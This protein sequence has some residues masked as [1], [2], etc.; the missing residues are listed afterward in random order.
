MNVENVRPLDLV[1]WGATGYT[2]A[3]VAEYLTKVVGN[4]GRLRWAVGGRSDEK[5]EAL[6]HRLSRIDPA[7][8]SLERIVAG[9]DDEATLRPMVERTR[10]VCSTVGPYLLYGDL[11]VDLC[12]EAGT[13]YCDL[14][15]EVPWI[16][17]M[18]D[19]NHATAKA[20]GA[21]LVH[22]CG[23][24]SV[25]SDLG[26]FMVQQAARALHGRP[27]HE[28]KL[29]VTRSAGSLSG[30]TMAS[31]LTMIER[32]DDP[33]IPQ[34]FTD[35]YALNPPGTWRGDDRDRMTIHFDRDLGQWTGP[36]V[37]AGINRP[38]VRRTK[39]LLG[40]VYGDDFSYVEEQAT[41][42]G[43]RGLGRMAKMVAFQGAVALP[44]LFEPSR[45][46]MQRFVL[47]APGEGPSPEARQRGSFEM[48]VLGVGQTASRQRFEV[49][50]RVAGD[51][52][53]GYGETSKS[54]SAS[55]PSASPSTARRSRTGRACSPRPRLWARSCSS[56]SGA[57][58]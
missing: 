28:V 26:C 21:R 49:W 7:V 6:V 47:P 12:A 13:H 42:R 29:F 9:A 17:K 31:M 50:G 46:L 57:P 52:D 34:M 30:G 5:L 55:P 53:P 10:V 22:A 20:S 14:A 40:E 38:V 1:L 19:R 56:A 45:R 41:G 48:R 35:P 36:F 37:M 44:L 58:V 32:S 23:F 15:G 24:D 4:D 2:G 16:R 25:P 54:C 39:A 3:L 11:L 43:V 51:T 27:C 18:I 8:R 33:T